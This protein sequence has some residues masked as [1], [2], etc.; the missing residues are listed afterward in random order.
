M[1]VGLETARFLVTVDLR[2]F[3]LPLWTSRFSEKEQFLSCRLARV[4]L[5]SLPSTLVRKTE[6]QS[7]IKISLVEISLKRM[8]EIRRTPETF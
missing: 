7:T 4:A 8:L 6:E 1:V 2:S 3:R 5:S